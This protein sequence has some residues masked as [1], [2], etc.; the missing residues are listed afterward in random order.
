MI[1]DP[2]RLT[3]LGESHDISFRDDHLKVQRTGGQPGR[4]LTIVQHSAPGERLSFIS[5][6]D[7]RRLFNW[8]GVW[9]HK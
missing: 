1:T 2:I 6:E 9:L 5:E 4:E 8:L 7:A 3:D